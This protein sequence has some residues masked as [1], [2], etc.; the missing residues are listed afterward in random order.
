[1]HAGWV[2]PWFLYV[3]H[4]RPLIISM[5]CPTPPPPPPPPISDGI[6]CAFPGGD[7]GSGLSALHAALAFIGALTDDAAD[8]RVLIHPEQG[9][10]KFLL[11]NPA[12]HFSQVI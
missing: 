9:T 11:L 6:M 8:G 4:Y 12:A 3:P 5:T 7:E 2:T 1:M 10:L